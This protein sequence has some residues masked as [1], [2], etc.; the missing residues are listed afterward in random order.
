[1]SKGG[2]TPTKN[3]TL[4]QYLRARRLSLGLSYQDVADESGLHYSYWT[5]LENGKYEQPAPR[6]LRI[7]ARVLGAPIEDLYSL[8]GYDMPERL[9]TFTPYLRAKYHLPAEAVADLERYFE[10]LRAYYD[11]PAD[12]PVFPP[13]PGSR[14]DDSDAGDEQDQRRAA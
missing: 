10:L 2:R 5:K 8:V 14:N 7:I 11:I 12:Q 13:K 3:P 4:G 9:P 1:M 6:Y